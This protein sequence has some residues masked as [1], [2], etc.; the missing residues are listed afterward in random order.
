MNPSCPVFANFNKVGPPNLIIRCLFFLYS[1]LYIYMHDIIHHITF[2]SWTL[3][4]R[5]RRKTHINE[6]SYFT[7]WFDCFLEGSCK[8]WMQGR[9]IFTFYYSLSYSS[10]QF[11]RFL[12]WVREA[13][14][15]RRRKYYCM[16]ESTSRWWRAGS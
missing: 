10:P 5:R 7:I 9:L 2:C 12:G 13:I 3:N 16:A 8:K 14:L 4:T 15:D 11:H 1:Y 6:F